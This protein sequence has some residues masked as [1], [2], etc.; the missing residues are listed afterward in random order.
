VGYAGGTTENPTY[1][2]IGDH[3][4]TLQVDF[5]PSIISYEE[6]LDVFWS[7]HNPALRGWS[8]QYRSVIFTADDGQRD[9]AERSF[10]SENRRLGGRIATSIEPLKAFYPAEDYHQKFYLRQ[11]P[12][13]AALFSAFYPDGHSLMN[14]PAAAKVN[15]FLSGQGSREHLERIIH[16]L[17]LSAEGERRL[18]LRLR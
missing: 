2:D 7:G 3:T 6:L 14:S 1:D 16:L 8:A 4:E 11:D 17:G 10:A 12:V 15:G 13:M 18:L 5:D 9:K